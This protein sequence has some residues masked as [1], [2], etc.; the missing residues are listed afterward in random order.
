MTMRIILSVCAFFLFTFS[1][2][3]VQAE[4]LRLLTWGGYAPEE[5]IQKFEAE[6]PDI[7]VEV[8]PSNNEQMVA[9]LRATGGAGFDLAQPT[10]ERIYLPQVEHNIYKPL[11]LTRIDTSKIEQSFL[12]AA[13]ETASVDGEVYGLPHLWGSTGLMVN[14]SQAPN[15]TRWT[16]LCEP[17]YKGRISMRL[18]RTILLGFAISMGYD[19]IN[20]WSN[21]DEYQKILDDVTQKLIDCKDNVKAY[22]QAGDDLTAMMSTGEI[23]AS[24]S[25]DQTAYKLFGEN[26]D[27]VYVPP[28]SG[29]HGWI[30]TFALPRKGKADDA[31]YKWINFVLRP[32]NVE[33]IQR[34]SGSV[35]TVKGADALL[36]EGMKNAIETAFTTT[37][38]DNLQFFPPIPPGVEELEGKALDKIKAATGS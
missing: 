12:D 24:E 5:L 11:D 15:I 17:E 7:T 20:S 18:K 28:E 14:K 19:P 2:L 8:T 29:A 35:A 16:D 13:K 30:D 34:T 38:I 22:W 36:S 26:N 32:E 9:K 31:A 23:V 10:L 25:W 21:L 3:N 4:T 6:Y 37:D 33:I 27:I 1:V